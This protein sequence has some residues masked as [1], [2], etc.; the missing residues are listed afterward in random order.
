MSKLHIRTTKTSSKATAVQVIYYEN[1]RRI[2]V[3]HI[4][5]SHNQDELKKLKLI[6]LGYINKLTSQQLLF[7]KDMQ[8]DLVNL[9]SVEYLGFRYGLLY[10]TLLGLSKKFNFHRHKN[11]LL[12]DLVIARIIQ[13]G[14]KFQAIEFLK[15][16][17]GIEHRREYL[18]RKLPK[19]EAIK[20]QV[21]SKISNIA[22]EEFNF[23]FSFIFY[24]VTT[25]YF[26]SDK[27]DDFRRRGFSKDNKFNQPQ[28]VLGLI[29]T[30]EVSHC[31]IKY[32]REISL[33]VIHLSLLSMNINR[34]IRL[35]L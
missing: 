27:E 22:K 20:K 3:K 29:V 25:L 8:S 30:S 16:F 31:G 18:Y 35:I 11:Q 5:S 24:D 19:L 12:L 34:I 32:L 26:E 13:P 23:N 2:I 14:S 33:K 1:R 15:D 21:A 7:P 4:G 28:I 10:E 17:L 9:K 6:A